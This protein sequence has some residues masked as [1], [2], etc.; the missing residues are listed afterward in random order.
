MVVVV[1]FALSMITEAEGPLQLSL[2]QIVNNST[3][4]VGC[5]AYFFSVH[6]SSCLHPV[7]NV[8]VGGLEDVGMQ[9]RVVRAR[10]VGVVDGGR[11]AVL[12][13]ESVRVAGFKRRGSLKVHSSTLV[14][15]RRR[16]N[17]IK[18]ADDS[19]HTLAAVVCNE[20]T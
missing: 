8:E 16:A 19:Q 5:Q 18:T 2:M 20:H 6:G 10:L 11:L 13:A 12:A 1:W 17:M 9:A 15:S 4:V 7:F 14:P 3:F